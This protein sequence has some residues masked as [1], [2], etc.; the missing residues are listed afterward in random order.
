M[1]FYL[2]TMTSSSPGEGTPVRVL[3]CY[4][5]GTSDYPLSRVAYETRLGAS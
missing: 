3:H 5:V 4:I 1:E 2:Q